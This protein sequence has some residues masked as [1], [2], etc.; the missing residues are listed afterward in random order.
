MEAEHDPSSVPF[1][2]EA[3]F[4]GSRADRDVTLAALHRLEAASGMAASG[5]ESGWLDQVLADLRLMGEALITEREESLR[6]DSLLSMIARGYPRR[7]GS[8]IRHLRAE[9]DDINRVLSALRTRLEST[10]KD[11]T[12]VADL[13]QQLG[14]LVDAIRRRR[15]RETDLVYEAIHLDLGGAD[16][17][18]ARGV[19]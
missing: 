16:H 12:D 5:R 18:R 15:E 8:R 1:E 11:R 10:A 6:P 17:E 19:D 13:R 3:A 2:R 9:Q 14:G 4:A 7:F